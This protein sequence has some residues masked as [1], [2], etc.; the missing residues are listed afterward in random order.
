MSYAQFCSAKEGRSPYETSSQICVQ[1]THKYR[2]VRRCNAG[3]SQER[4]Q[5]SYRISPFLMLQ[6]ALQRCS[7]R[8]RSPAIAWT[9]CEKKKVCRFQREP[10]LPV[11]TK[12]KICWWFLLSICR[13]ANKVMHNFHK[14]VLYILVKKAGDTFY[15]NT[16]CWWFQIL[17]DSFFV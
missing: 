10:S 1:A 16:A 2:R 8:E 13:K 5:A 9:V 11:S 6:E 7:R 15:M 14:P 12:C 17:P 4:W 3:Q